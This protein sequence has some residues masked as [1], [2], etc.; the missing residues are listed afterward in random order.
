[1][2]VAFSSGL[3]FNAPSAGETATYSVLAARDAKIS[4]H[5]HTGAGL[6]TQIAAGAIAANA[7]GGPAIRLANNVALR[8]RNAAGSADVDALKVNASNLVVFPSNIGM[9]QTIQ[10][11]TAA[12]G[13]YALTSSW[14]TLSNAGAA[15]AT[16]S[17]PTAA[18]AGMIAFVTNIGAGTWTITFSGRA[19]ASDIATVPTNCS[20]ILFANGTTSWV[21]FASG[22][23]SI[24]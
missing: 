10:P 17:V 2:T 23:A 4:A 19:S 1:M 11:L 22:G 3:N 12:A 13:T 6:G 14:L 21:P 18:Q 24:A 20:L 8:A 9:G 16:I 15:A 5:D 7:V